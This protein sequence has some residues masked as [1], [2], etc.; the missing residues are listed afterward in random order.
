VATY[1]QIAVLAGLPGHARQVGYALNAMPDEGLA[2]WHRVTNSQGAVSRRAVPG[3]EFV[4]R[5]LL[6]A[7]GVRFGP[8]GRISLEEY[9]WD[10][11]ARPRKRVSRTN[12]SAKKVARKKVARKKVV[13]RARR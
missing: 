9:G 10:P 4:Q 12:A 3:Y 1:G 11:D 13:S 5:G 2:P 8:G 7:E 6:E